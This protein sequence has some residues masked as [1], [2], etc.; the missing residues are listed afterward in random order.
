MEINKRK[1]Y[2]KLYY[3][4]NKDKILKKAC[5]KCKCELCGREVIKNNLNTHYQLNICKTTQ[6]RNDL[7]KKR[8]KPID[9]ENDIYNNI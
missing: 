9:N 6:E 3:E 4:N 5:A 7:I 8:L 1:E 2:N